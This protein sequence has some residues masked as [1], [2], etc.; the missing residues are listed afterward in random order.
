MPIYEYRCV[1]CNHTFEAFL[2]SSDEKALCPQCQTSQ[3]QRLM[4]TFASTV[5]GG[6]KAN[7]ISTTAPSAPAATTPKTGGC[8]G[9]CACH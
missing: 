2:A 9:G 8:G 6:Y 3:L 4:S 5:Q 1:P 7:Q